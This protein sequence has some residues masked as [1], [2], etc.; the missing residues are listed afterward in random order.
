MRKLLALVSAL[1]LALS[2][3]F[4][5]PRIA[6]AQNGPIYCNQMGTAAPSTA[7]T[8]LVVA[9]AAA[10][11]VERILI[12]GW[13]MQVTGGTGQLVYGTTVSTPC[14]TGQKALSLVFAAGVAAYDLGF[15]FRGL[16]VPAGNN[17][18]I[19]TGTSTTASIVEVFY[20][21]Q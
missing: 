5:I 10:S 17:V 2:M 20:T 8:T 9:A 3:Q 16:A 19:I 21:Y 7:T 11:S 12:C 13:N 14:D 18:C 1:A 6:S 4:Y 15:L